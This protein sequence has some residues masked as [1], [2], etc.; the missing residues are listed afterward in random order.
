MV[1]ILFSLYTIYVKEVQGQC[2]DLRTDKNFLCLPT[3]KFNKLM[4]HSDPF[5]C[6][7]QQK[8]REAEEKRSGERKLER[9]S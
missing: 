1:H 7:R 4:M 5:S 2:A 6:G 3:S 8:R 9:R